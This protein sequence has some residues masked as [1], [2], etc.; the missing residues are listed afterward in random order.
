MVEASDSV[1]PVSS[2]SEATSLPEEDAN[3]SPPAS[4]TVNASTQKKK[5]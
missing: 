3:P 5:R 4:S 2:A 1:R